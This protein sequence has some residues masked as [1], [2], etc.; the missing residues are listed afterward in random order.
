M[1]EHNEAIVPPRELQTV[2]F[3]KF[4]QKN[5]RAASVALLVQCKP[6]LHKSLGSTRSRINQRLGAHGW[7]PWGG[8]PRHGPQS[9][10]ELLNPRGLK[11]AATVQAQG[12]L[13]LF[14]RWDPGSAAH[15]HPENQT[16]VSQDEEFFFLISAGKKKKKMSS[17]NHLKFNHA[18]TLRWRGINSKNCFWR[19]VLRVGDETR[20]NRHRLLSGWSCLGLEKKQDGAGVWVGGTGFVLGPSQSQIDH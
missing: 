8:A 19:N 17:L 2:F 10:E 16:L 3:F 6:S 5:R 15:T 20:N 1:V 11:H 7:N 18:N 9:R 4:T 14:S 13:E 12:A